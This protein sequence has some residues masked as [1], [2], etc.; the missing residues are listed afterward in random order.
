MG[1][2][3]LQKCAVN[4]LPVA[5]NA[6]GNNPAEINIT[7]QAKEG[8]NMLEVILA[9]PSSVTPLESWK[10]GSGALHRRSLADEP[11]HAARA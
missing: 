9:Q 5:C 11:A 1:V 7:K 8:R 2:G 10:E 6:D 3:Q 4:G